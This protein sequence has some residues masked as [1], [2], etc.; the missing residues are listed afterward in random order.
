MSLSRRE[1][2]VS[3]PA[4]LVACRSKDALLEPGAAREGT[5]HAIGVRV[6]EVKQVVETEP[7][8]EGAGVRLRRA[9]GTRAL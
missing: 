4:T 9:L 2:L 3:L 1:L 5:A 7:T 6:R 8:M